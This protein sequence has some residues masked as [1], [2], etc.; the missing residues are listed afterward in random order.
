MASNT[1]LLEGAVSS[2]L[3]FKSTAAED[4]ANAT[5][6]TTS[7][8]GYAAEGTAYQT[9]ADIAAQNAVIAQTSGDIK[10]LQE[11]RTLGITVGEQ[12]AQVAASGFGASGSN[13]S[14]LRSSY[15][16]GALT[17]Q[18][19]ATQTALTKGG[20]LEEEAASLA[21]KKAT[22]VTSTAATNA[23]TGYTKASTTATANAANETAAINNYVGT[24]TLT[25]DE[26]LILAPLNS[27]VGTP[28]TGT[29][30]GTTATT[31]KD[32]GTTA[33]SS[34]TGTTTAAPLSTYNGLTWGVSGNSKLA[35]F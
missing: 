3:G 11:Q 9:A 2:T 4:T 24:G 33:T 6:S 19:T 16:Q 5:A 26:S 13:L 32:A 12:K 21:E 25:A 28:T 17:Q 30:T 23:A 7:A 34:T 31:V 8:T 22:D 14:L 15:Q 10:T 35:H 1:S 29:T 20:Y 18:L 27:T